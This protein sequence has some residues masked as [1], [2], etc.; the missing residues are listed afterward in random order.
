MFTQIIILSCK[1]PNK[2]NNCNFFHIAKP[3]TLGAEESKPEVKPIGTERT[4][5]YIGIKRSW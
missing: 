2:Y 1:G 3:P 5:A 4:E